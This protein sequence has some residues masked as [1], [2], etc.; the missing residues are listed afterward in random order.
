MADEKEPFFIGGATGNNLEHQPSGL[1]WSLD[2]WLYTTINA[3]SLRYNI[4]GGETIRENP[5]PD[6][7]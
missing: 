3:F 5:P 6:R 2:N 4:H 7:G 1:I